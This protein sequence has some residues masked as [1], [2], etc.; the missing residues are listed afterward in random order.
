MGLL[1]TGGTT[2][3]ATPYE[4]NRWYLVELRF[5]WDKKQVAFYVDGIVQQRHIPFRRETSCYIGACALGNRDKCTTW[6]DSIKFVRESRL[7]CAEVPA[8]HGQAEAWIGPLREECAAEGFVLRVEDAAGNVGET[9]G[10]LFPLT[11][12]E[13]AQ[14]VAINSAALNDITALLDEPD[15]SD[16][17][18]PHTLPTLPPPSGASAA[19]RLLHPSPA[20]GKPTVAT[21]RCLAASSLCS[22]HGTP[23][24]SPSSSQVVFV[25]EGKPLHAHRCIL[26]ARCE[27]FR[28]MFN[29]SMREGSRACH[30]VPV[31]EV[32]HA[33]FRCMLQYIYGGAV[34]VPEELAVELL[35]LADRCATRRVPMPLRVLA[36]SACCIAHCCLAPLSAI[37]TD[38]PLGNLLILFTAT[39]SAGSSSCAAS[40]LRRWWASRR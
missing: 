20:L 13:G 8:R 39:S 2:H 27:A 29:S 6:F 16:V 35:G 34:H 30:E 12:S 28:G 11:R 14:R 1:G 10:P 17:R 7:F 24:S 18:T 37:P 26:T 23:R 33:A 22:C 38:P 5:D 36:L 9:L 40:R 3:G 4:P 31:H 21:H 32:S 15:S 25:A 19:Y